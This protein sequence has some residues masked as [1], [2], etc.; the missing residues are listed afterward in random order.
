MGEMLCYALHGQIV[1]YGLFL[2]RFGDGG[3]EEVKNRMVLI[4][5]SGAT[6]E[7][8]S[9]NARADQCRMA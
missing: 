3:E 8:L 9:N 5:V 1:Y 6:L 2:E 7:E 4:N